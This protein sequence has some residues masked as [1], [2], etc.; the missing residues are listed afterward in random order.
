ML[1]LNV[2]FSVL[3]HMG[4]QGEVPYPL[5]LFVGLVPWLFFSNAI[6]VATESVSGSAGLVTKVYFPR[7]VLPVAAILGKLIEFAI[8]LGI[9]AAFLLLYRWPFH[10]SLVWLP[11]VLTLQLLFT[12]G[13]ALPLSALNLYYH[14]V[15]YLV[16]VALQLG[17]F[18]SP[19]FY[20]VELIPESYR[21]IFNWNPN[22]AFINAYRSIILAGE[23]PDLA[24]LAAGAI[25]TFLTLI[26]GYYFFKRLEGSFAD[27]V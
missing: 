1:V 23:A 3:L 4:G 11:A 7:E 21:T 25:L 12:V 20:S 10:A 15:R 13:V 9:L 19:I 18:L 5:F 14:D 22:T 24:N 27:V 6:G 2:V 16:G 8:G 17:M 26:L